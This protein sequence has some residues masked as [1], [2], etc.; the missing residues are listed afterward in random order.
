V[1]E[2]ISLL[3]FSPLFSVLAIFV[4]AACSSEETILPGERIAIVAADQVDLAV[5]AEAATEGV[6]LP[7]AR[8]NTIFGAPGQNAS[9]SG[10]H[11]FFEGALNRAFSVDVGISAELGTEMAQPVAN[12]QAV[13]TITPGGEVTA[14]DIRTGATIWELDI[15]PST[16]DTQLSSTGG[17]ALAETP[18]GDELYVHANKKVLIALNAEDGAE[19]WRVDFDV[20]LGGGPT[21]GN[22]VIIV[23][24]LDGRLYALSDLDGQELWNRVGAQSETGIIGSASPAVFGDEVINV[25]SDGEL[26]ALSLAQGEFFWGENLTPIELRTAIDGIADIR[27]HPVHDGGLIFV[28]SHSGALFAFNAQSGWVIWE[29]PLRGIEM[30]W[31]SGQSLFVTTIDGRVF[32]LRRRDGAPR[33]V[34]E[35]P[36]AYDSHLSVAENAPRYTSAVVASGKVIVASSEGNLHILD[37]ETGDQERRLSVGGAVTT[38][39]IIA[40][41]TIFVINRSGELVAFR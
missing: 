2:M 40:N 6:L 5:N 23:S 4:L 7:V 26:L 24:D 11:F 41:G 14:S 8:R 38:P 17:L 19:K 3:R 12:G 37:A 15:D 22:G 13:F 39:P 9:H 32:A 34:S 20:F 35:L 30:P 33:W 1:N 18:R 28:I 16:D 27:A 10:G 25:G 36:G 21:V 31:L 29:K